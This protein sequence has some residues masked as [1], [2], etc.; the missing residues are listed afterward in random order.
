[1]AG[2]SKHR[3]RRYKSKLKES[4]QVFNI[5]A[6]PKRK[7][8]HTIE[9]SRSFASPIKTAIQKLFTPP[10]AVIRNEKV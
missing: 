3:A 2:P 6:R 4:F 5:Y 8:S 7:R 9:D 1:M 10:L